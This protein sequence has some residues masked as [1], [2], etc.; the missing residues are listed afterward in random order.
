VNLAIVGTGDVAR[1]YAAALAR[2]PTLRLVGAA[3]R[4]PETARS[5]CRSHNCTYYPSLDRLLADE[6]V[7]IVLNLTTQAAHAEIT[8]ACLRA[9]KH[10]YTEKPLA[11]GVADA[12]EL[13]AIAARHRVRLAAAPST[14]LAPPQLLAR[15]V[16]RSGQLGAVRAVYAEANWGRIEEWHPRPAPFY[17]VGAVVD[18]GVYP[19]TFLVDALGPVRRVSAFGAHLLRARAT[20]SGESFQATAPDIVVAVLE[21]AS[22]VFVRLTASF[23][24]GR[25]SRQSGIQFHGDEASL[26]LDDWFG[27][28]GR[29]ALVTPGG[30]PL[31]LPPPHGCFAGVD[32]TLGLVDLEEAIREG[33]PERAS[34]RLAAHVAEVCAAVMRASDEGRA[35]DIESTLGGLP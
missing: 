30:S 13:V 12:R 3:S 7:D 17:E 21:L 26:L 27:G 25:S 9:G 35:I 31:P 11:L 29:V 28:D 33:R 2:R 20:R 18:V 32:Y 4:T 14:F 24:V 19:I 23:F 34:G 10:V 16:L 15:E 22:G 6:R 1:Q 8:S 5:F